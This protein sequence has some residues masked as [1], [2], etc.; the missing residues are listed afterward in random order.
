MED[1]LQILCRKWFI[2]TYCIEGN[3]QG[4]FFVHT[5]NG[6][7]RNPREA[8]KLKQMGTQAGFPDVTIYNGSEKP[9][10]VELKDKRG[11]LSKSQKEFFSVFGQFHRIFVVDSLEGFQDLINRMF[12]EPTLGIVVSQFFENG[13]K[14]RELDNVSYHLVAPNGDFVEVPKQGAFNSLYNEGMRGKIL[15]NL[16]DQH[17]DMFPQNFRG[18]YTDTDKYKWHNYKKNGN[19]NS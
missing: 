9:F 8:K 16:I 17:D 1:S 3:P 14:R 10:Y 11:S 5:P 18:K 7:L 15:G 19:N 4:R 2:N 13:C 6:G 12:F